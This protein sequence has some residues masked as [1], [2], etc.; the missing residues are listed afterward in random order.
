VL[1]VNSDY[2]VNSWGKARQVAG[3]VAQGLSPS[4]W[5]RLSSGEGTKGARLHDWAYLELADL[6]S[7]DYGSACS[8]LWTRG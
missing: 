4:D 5:V 6:D 2:R 7:A 3:A 8:G 1:G